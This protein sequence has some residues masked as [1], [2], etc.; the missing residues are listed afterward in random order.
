MVL[1]NT[2][3]SRLF[4]PRHK[5][6]IHILTGINTD[7]NLNPAVF[8]FLTLNLHDTSSGSLNDVPE[9]DHQRTKQH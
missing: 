3:V 4:H 1:L 5:E 8:H 7:W 6:N 9:N 2:A